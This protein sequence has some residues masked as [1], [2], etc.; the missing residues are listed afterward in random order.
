M[1]PLTEIFLP[2]SVVA[3]EQP[4]RIEFFDR[5]FN[6]RID[7]E[8]GNIV[9]TVEDRIQHAILTPIYNII[10]PMVELAVVSKN[11]S[12][13]RDAA[14]VMASLEHGERIRIRAPF[15]NA[16]ERNNTFHKF[17]ANGETRRNVPDEVS[18]LL[19][20]TPHSDWQS[21]TQHNGMLKILSTHPCFLQG[22]TPPPLRGQNGT[23]K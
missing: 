15:R 14:S 4:M 20:S 3:I 19:V 11:A 7:R 12:P 5:C 18:D 13:G 17:S 22:F 10:S 9:A 2:I 6:E 21:R 23:V 16:S 1:V 8:M